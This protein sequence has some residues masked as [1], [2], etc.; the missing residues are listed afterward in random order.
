MITIEDNLVIDD[1]TD[2][3]QRRLSAESINS[4]HVEIIHEEDEMATS[5]R[6]EDLTRTLVNVA[7][8]HGLKCLR[9]SVGVE[10]H[11]GVDALL[12]VKGHEVVLNDSGLTST[13]S[14]DV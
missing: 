13:S 1:L 14:T 2:Q 3:T 8:K 10:V 4:R 5:S 6:T 12:L 7:L 9:V 11:R